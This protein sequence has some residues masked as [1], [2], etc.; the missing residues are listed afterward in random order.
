MK[1]EAD[2]SHST[3]RPPFQFVRTD[4]IA[5]NKK[6]PGTMSMAVQ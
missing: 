3:G 5:D 2:L 6:P 4:K 1:K